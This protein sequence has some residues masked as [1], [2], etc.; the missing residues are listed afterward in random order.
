MSCQLR[1]LPLLRRQP[2]R[3]AKLLGARARHPATLCHA[4]FG[5]HT[6]GI[7]IAAM[8]ALEGLRN[9]GKVPLTPIV[10]HRAGGQ[11][12]VGLW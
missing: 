7:F 4:Q 6:P 5:L 10:C 8:R 2:V 9:W 11:H 12:A 1:Q 3:A